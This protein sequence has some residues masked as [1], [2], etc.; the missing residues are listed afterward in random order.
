LE[1]LFQNC[2]ILIGNK[3][4]FLPLSIYPPYSTSAIIQYQ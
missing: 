2:G 1:I 3:T 4:R